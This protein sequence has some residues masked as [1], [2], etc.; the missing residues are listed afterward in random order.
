MLKRRGSAQVNASGQPLLS[1]EARRALA[2]MEISQLFEH[3]HRALRAAARPLH[4]NSKCLSS[5]ELARMA[6]PQGASGMGSKHKQGANRRESRRVSF[7]MRL[8][9]HMLLERSSREARLSRGRCVFPM[10]QASNACVP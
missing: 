10:W 3:Q 2:G 4:V 8:S 5:R 7:S 1:P 6:T 9:E